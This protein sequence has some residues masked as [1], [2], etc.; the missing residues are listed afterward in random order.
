MKKHVLISF[1]LLT[2]GFVFTVSCQKERKDSSMANNKVSNVLDPESLELYNKIVDAGIKHNEY[3][4]VFLQKFPI[5]FFENGLVPELF[6]SILGYTLQY[7]TDYITPYSVILVLEKVRQNLNPEN[8]SNYDYTDRQKLVL[9]E[10]KNIINRNFS[11]YSVEELNIKENVI[12]VKNLIDKD[13]NE[14]LISSISNPNYSEQ[15]KALYLYPIGIA[16]ASNCFWFDKD[17]EVYKADHDVIKT[18]A[19]AFAQISYALIEA[20]ALDGEAQVLSPEEMEEIAHVSAVA[21]GLDY[22]GK[23]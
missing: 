4:E 20:K 11:R 14:Y 15:E 2:I 1:F 23:K 19:E 7:N 5:Q 10:I 9:D 22:S 18:D 3:A 12:K 6:N 8:Y 17:L 13:L 16:K 21:S